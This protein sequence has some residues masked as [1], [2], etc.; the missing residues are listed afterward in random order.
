VRATVSHVDA[1]TLAYASLSIVGLHIVHDSFLQPEPG[2]S[3]LDHLAG[4]LIPLA[5]LV[6][7]RSAIT[8]LAPVCEQRL[9]L[10]SAC[11]RWSSAQRPAVTE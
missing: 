8:V 1:S 10:S 6:S 7:R 4:G 11:L 3:A 2:T 9:R 5:A